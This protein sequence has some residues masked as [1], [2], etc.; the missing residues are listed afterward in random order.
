MYIR[1]NTSNDR[2]AV[3]KA[4]LIQAVIFS[5]D[6]GIYSIVTKDFIVKLPEQEA[7]RV[8]DELAGMKELNSARVNS[9]SGKLSDDFLEQFNSDYTL[10]E[11]QKAEALGENHP[12]LQG[13]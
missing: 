3:V 13:N 5:Q 8:M 4:E 10:T 7:V 12:Q 11:N 2:Q 9:E 1:V 6:M